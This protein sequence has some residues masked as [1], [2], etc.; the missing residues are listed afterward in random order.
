MRKRNVIHRCRTRKENGCFVDMYPAYE[1]ACFILSSSL[2]LFSDESPCVIHRMVTIDL[3]MDCEITGL[4]FSLLVLSR[5]II[6]TESLMSQNYRLF[7]FH[8]YTYVF[9][10]QG[11]CPNYGK[12]PPSFVN[13]CIIS[14]MI[15][16][17]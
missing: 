12:S 5:I 16:F 15:R 4:Q 11:L 17:S 13:H 1:S 10:P 3:M 2:K 7:P 14:N 9:K 6:I 8:S